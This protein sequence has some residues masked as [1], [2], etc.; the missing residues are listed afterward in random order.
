MLIFTLWYIIRQNF[1]IIKTYFIIFIICYTGLNYINI[2]KVIAKNNIDRYFQTG[3]IDIAYLN[4]LSLDSVPEMSRL[5][6]AKDENVAGKEKE[7]FNNLKKRL[8]KDR[9][10]IEYNYSWYRAKE[11]VNR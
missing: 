8:N 2:D 3:H 11:I 7:H 6:S 9:R 1:N 5:L 4:T 10:L